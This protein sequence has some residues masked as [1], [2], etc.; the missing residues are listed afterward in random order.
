MRIWQ[1]HK[2]LL[3]SAYNL[4]DC[5]CS[6]VYIVWF[7]IK[8]PIVGSGNCSP[9][10]TPVCLNYFE[11]HTTCDPCLLVYII[12]NPTVNIWLFS[13]LHFCQITFSCFFYQLLS[14]FQMFQ[15][16]NLE[17]KYGE[18]ERTFKQLFSPKGPLKFTFMDRWNISSM[19][20]MIKWM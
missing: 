15:R 12:Q 2:V 1:I 17:W 14:L 18:L 19:I 4:W 9:Y 6:V 5:A 13:S 10:F 16:Y 8:Y 3:L 11:T 7:L 20:R